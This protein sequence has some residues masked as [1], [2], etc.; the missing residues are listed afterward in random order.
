MKRF[1]KLFILLGALVLLATMYFV[2]TLVINKNDTPN[3]DDDTSNQ[4]N[5]N[6]TAAQIDI[7]SMYA[8]SYNIDSDKF[9]FSL[10]D[11]STAWLWNENTDLPLDNTYFAT[12]ASALELVTTD[13]KLKVTSGE[14]ATY[15]LADPWL[16]V[17]VSDNTY[18]T[19]TFSFGARNSFNSKYYFSSSA[20]NSSVYMV[21]ATI[22]A[23][24]IYTPYQMVKND[25]L[26]T[27]EAGSIKSLS[28]I[29]SDS[30]TVYTYYD[31]GKDDLSET[32]DFWYVSTNGET[33]V[34]LSDALSGIID[35]AYDTIVFSSPVGYT[36]DE[37]H[38]FG[39]TEP[40]ILEIRYTV[41]KT[42]TDA[43]SGTSSTVTV[44]ETAS[45]LLGYSDDDGNIYAG[46]S[47]SVLSYSIDGNVL[48][49]LYNAITK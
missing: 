21:D 2:I 49:Q 16:S 13:L 26:P 15:G 40:T 5:T 42:V 10:N 27:I 4:I 31:G 44:D 14:L 6:Y 19:Q 24:F 29:S 20:D 28:F 47:N 18:G 32:D 7:Q 25:T 43:T 37:R 34:R 3:S 22:P 23:C 30:S 45:V 12:M 1:I 36:E 41:K 39:L 38:E 8:I 33:E 35:T 46:V 11:N 48:S 17:T 9:S